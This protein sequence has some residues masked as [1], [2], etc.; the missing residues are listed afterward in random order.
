[1]SEMHRLLKRQ[2]RR[3]LR[4]SGATPDDWQTLL[5][6]I[7]LYYYEADQEKAL[8]E[9][10]LD[11]NS[12][13]L[14]SI[15]ERLRLQST[16]MTH[17][18]LDTLSE[19]VFATDA[20]GRFTFLNTAAEQML[21]WKE[22]EVAGRSAQDI[23]VFA[24]LDGE[25]VED[26]A[27]QFGQVLSSGKVMAYE[28]CFVCRDQRHLPVHFRIHPLWQS[29]KIVGTLVSFEDISQRRQHEELIWTQANFDTL[30]QLPNRRMF[31][32]RLEQE[33][34]KFSRTAIPLAL[35][36]IDLD[37]FKEV[38]DTLGHEIGDALLIEAAHRILSTVR[39][40]DTVAR[41]GG[42]EFTVI[43]S[44][45]GEINQVEKI[46]QNILAK[47]SMPFYL[48]NKT[49]YISASIG[50]TFYPNDAGNLEQLLKYADQAMYVA[51]NQ[52]R[53]RY[54]FFTPALQEAAQARLRMINDLRNALQQQQFS[55]CLQPIVHLASGRIHKAESLIRWQHPEHCMIPPSK[56][57]LIAEESGLID[58]IG[59]WVFYES[60]RWLPRCIEIAGKDFQ[61]S[62]NKSPVQFM[63]EGDHSDWLAHLDK[64]HLYGNNLVVEITEGLLLNP[65]SQITDKLFKFRDAGVQIAID[66]FGTG[67][68][69]LA[70]LKKFHIDYLKIDQNFVRD[71]TTN[72]NDMAL[73]EAMIVMA[74]KL[75]LQV[76]AEGV[77]TAEQR[78]LLLAAGCDYAQGYYFARP[79]PPEAFEE[80][81]LNN[82]K[83][84]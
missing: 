66:D 44:Q 75:G 5:N 69:S 49:T 24:Q 77:E 22:S 82:L 59:D 70:Y 84:D 42:D 26:T 72:P 76:T 21:G 50:I 3:Y 23:I 39:E 15:N 37:H 78:D 55:I 8:L 11:V 30:T 4:S 19:G 56:F 74:H 62:V 17:T 2:L 63:R 29:G 13:E 51:K 12:R 80:L 34:K 53:N 36:F 64:L 68:S 7:N 81:L 71:I 9:N 40:L 16:E 35:L 18:M 27:W 47:L 61:I 38:N 31:L 6:A 65:T 14:T 33:I 41:L 52:G 54:A 48:N 25:L 83:H 20:Q 57:I 79:L 46:A 43:L 10:A 32:S 1:M 28:K 58:A 60:V 45:V 73:C 67:Y